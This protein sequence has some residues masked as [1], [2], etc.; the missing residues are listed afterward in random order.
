MASPRRR[1]E[2]LTIRKF[3][4][5]LGAEVRDVD[6]GA[7]IDTK[8]F[9]EIY[10]ALLR[11]QVLV[12]PD[13]DLPAARQVEFGRL[14]GEPQVHVLNQ[15]HDR[16]HPELYLLSNLDQD[17]QPDGRHPDPGTLYWHTDGSWSRRRTI[18]TMLYSFEVPR[19]GGETHFADMYG[20]YDSL[21]DSLKRRLASLRA[22][23]NLNFHKKRRDPTPLTEDQVRQAPPVEHDVVRHH[24][25]TQRPTIYLGDMGET[26]VGMEYD[27][28]RALI[29]EVNAL[30]V[31]SELVYEHK[32]NPGELVLW[33]NRCVLHRSTPYDTATERRVI[34]RLTVLDAEP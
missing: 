34:R 6:L 28:G 31:H 21:P 18:V 4:A 2:S 12:F 29:E 25:D 15:Y 14:F 20:A 1:A 8:L 17:G 11:F 27:T 30:I 33:D 13:Q 19:R 10:Q 26:I 3:T 7:A 32:W 23:H 5:R 24:P 16:Q 22:V 9:V